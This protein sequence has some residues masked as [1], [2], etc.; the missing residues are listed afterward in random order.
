[1]V[2]PFCRM[3]R[4]G[5][6]SGLVRSGGRGVMFEVGEQ[7]EIEGVTRQGRFSRA[8]YVHIFAKASHL[9]AVHCNYI[10]R[11]HAIIR[12]RYGHRGAAD[13]GHRSDLASPRPSMAL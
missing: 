5:F 7:V 8:I 6:F 2:T 11:W 9:V 3:K 12:L 10:T 1:M 4:A 13:D